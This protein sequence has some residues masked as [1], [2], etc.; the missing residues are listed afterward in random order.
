MFGL[1]PGAA[2]VRG[3]VRTS[4]RRG[5]ALGAGAVLIAVGVGFVIAAVWMLLAQSFGAIAAS[6]VLAALL[7][8]AGLILVALAPKPAPLP[9]P[10]E[11]LRLQAAKGLLFRPSGGQPP[12]L[13]ALLFGLSVAIQIRASRRK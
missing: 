8:G 11:R 4:A 6:L 2:E 9:L 3:Y 10:E 5:L 1:L 7:L 13:E 12:L